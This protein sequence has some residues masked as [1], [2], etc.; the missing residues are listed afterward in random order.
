MMCLVDTV[1]LSPATAVISWWIHVQMGHGD[2]NGSYLWAQK[3]DFHSIKPIS[4]AT[5]ECCICWQQR[6]AE[7][8]VW[9]NP[10]VRPRPLMAGDS[11]DTSV[12][13]VL[14]LHNAAAKTTL[15]GPIHRAVIHRAMLLIEK[16]MSQ[17]QKCNSS[18]VNFGIH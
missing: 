8:L 3:Y 16:L 17:Q 18:I 6:P 10:R 14:S 12:M 5:A 13:D 11:S 9:H 7:S 4:W 2:Q 1:R 15:C